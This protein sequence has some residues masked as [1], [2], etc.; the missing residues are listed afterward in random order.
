M[1]EA[2]P[3][4]PAKNPARD[5]PAGH[6]HEDPLKLFSAFIQDKHPRHL[7]AFV[8]ILEAFGRYWKNIM[9][10]QFV[11]I[12]DDVAVAADINKVWVSNGGEVFVKLRDGVA[13]TVDVAYG[14]TPFQ[15]STRI[16]TQ[17]EA[18]LA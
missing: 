11:E 5:Q 13:H 15:A 10:N 3:L 9:A 1:R 2:S 8:D 7:A 4:P 17:I 12:R 16:K 6:R 14:E 18:A